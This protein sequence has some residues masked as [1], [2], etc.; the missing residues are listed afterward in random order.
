M[1]S[2]PQAG[3][4]TEGSTHFCYLEYQLQPDATTRDDVRQRYPVGIG[5]QRRGTLSETV[6]AFGKEC[7]GPGEPRVAP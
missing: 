3:I 2:S 6:I 7:L 1:S 4:F 5:C